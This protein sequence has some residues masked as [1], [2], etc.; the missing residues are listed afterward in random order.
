MI[1]TLKQKGPKVGRIIV[2]LGSMWAR[3]CFG[4]LLSTNVARFLTAA[5]IMVVGVQGLR[6][7]ENVP[8]RPFAEWADVPAQ[9]EFVLGFVYE[10][11]EAYRIWAGNGSHNI[12]VK[13]GG[14][15]YGIDINQGYLAMQYGIVE[16]W[17]ADL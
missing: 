6:G 4:L 17:A 14:E 12:T 10:E 8:H 9:G 16:K 1:R 3:K 7:S 13:S 11:S 15:S 5:A 2:Q